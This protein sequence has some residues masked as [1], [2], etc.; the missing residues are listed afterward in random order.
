MASVTRTTVTLSEML[1]EG[2]ES[3]SSK[4]RADLKKQKREARQKRAPKKPSDKGRSFARFRKSTKTEAEKAAAPLV[5]GFPYYVTPS[6][7]SHAGRFASVLQLY[8]RTGSNREKSFDDIIDMVPSDAMSGVDI[9]MVVDDVLVKYDEK[10]RLITNNVTTNKSTIEDTQRHGSKEETDN[11]AELIKQNSELEDYDDYQTIASSAEP[12]AVFEVKLIIVADTP[13]VIEEQIALVNLSLDKKHEGARWDAIGGDQLDR[14]TSLFRRIEPST[15][16]MTSTGSNYAGIDFAMSGGLADPRGVPVGIDVMSMTHSVSMLDFDNPLLSQAVIAA[17]R[18]STIYD[19]VRE[20]DRNT[21]TLSSLMAQAAA[22]QITMNGGRAHHI[23]LND[24]NYFEEGRYARPIETSDIFKRYDVSRETINPLQ[25]FGDLEDVVDIYSRLKLKTVNIFRI[26]TDLSLTDSD[27]AVILEALDQFYMGQQ[28][29]YT[30]AHLKPARTRIVDIDDPRTYATLG[31]FISSFRTL[32]RAAIR[33]GRE[34]KAERVDTLY[35]ILSNAINSYKGILASPTSIEPSNAPQVYYDFSRV[36]D[37]SI[38]QIQ[39]LNILEFVIAEAGE[40]DVVIIHGMDS[41]YRE[42]ALWTRPTI[43]AAQRRGARFIFCFDTI[44][45]KDSQVT[46]MSDIFKLKGSYYTDLD[47]EMDYSLIG[48]C[49]PAEVE[50]F[51]DAMNTKLSSTL[52]ARLMS[53]A[54]SQLL[55]HRRSDRINNFVQCSVLV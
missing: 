3:T 13:E 52:K 32:A 20:G 18:T 23:V 47:H 25:G 53:K 43:E 16:L 38:K 42:V 1:E 54:D 50:L 37:L 10:K 5:N 49:L 46:Q 19:Y 17:P 4:H 29:W 14:F 48:W 44:T 28:Y 39:Y 35:A 40:N 27:A 15:K 41:L 55:I 30:D 24:F 21:P 7:T 45:S 8:V 2:E 36:A 31:K 34:M 11:K 51:E 6:Y 26:L 22:N 9:Y 12:V 33:E